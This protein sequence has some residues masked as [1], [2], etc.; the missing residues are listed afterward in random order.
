M[1]IENGYLTSCTPA[2]CYVYKKVATWV[3]IVKSENKF[4]VCPVVEA[5]LSGFAYSQPRVQIIMGFTIRFFSSMH[6]F[7]Q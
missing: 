6:L 1:S 2:E 5:G 4:T 7:R 3:F